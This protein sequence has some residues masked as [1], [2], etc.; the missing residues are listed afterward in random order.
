MPLGALLGCGS[1]CRVY[2]GAQEA[3][4]TPQLPPSRLIDAVRTPRQPRAVLDRGESLPPME[5]FRSANSSPAAFEPAAPAAGRLASGT[6]SHLAPVA[7]FAAPVAL[8]GPVELLAFDEMAAQPGTVSLL[9]LGARVSLRDRFRPQPH[10]Y[11]LTEYIYLATLAGTPYSGGRPP[12]P[13]TTE[14]PTTHYCTVQHHVPIDPYAERMLRAVL[15]RS[16]TQS[17]LSLEAL[18]WRRVAS[19]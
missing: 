9:E 7:L 3:T 13:L 6:E 10:P 18:C 15:T 14:S 17:R 16:V 11:P 4:A 2:D 12:P 8:S 19:R 1:G 5:A